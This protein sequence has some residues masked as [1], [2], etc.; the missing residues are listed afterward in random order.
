M[1]VLIAEDDMVSRR[2]LQSFLE[3]WGHEVVAAADGAEAWDLFQNGEFPVVITDWMMPKMD[4]VQL[5]R[6][7][8]SS[9]P[10][11]YV[12]IVLLTAKSEKE[13]IVE[14]MEAGADDFLAKPFDRNELRARLRAG[15]RYLRQEQELRRARD[16]LELRVRER[17][18]ELANAYDSLKNEMTH[19]QR[20]AQERDAAQQQLLQMERDKKRFYK[21]VILAVTQ[22]RFCLVDAEEIPVEGSL[23]LSIPFEDA[24]GYRSLRMR[25]REVIEGLLHSPEAVGDLVL[26]VGEAVTNAIKHAVGGQFDLYLTADR[27]LARISDRGS[28]IETEHLP[29]SILTAGFSTK[30]SMGMG[31]TLMLQ[32][33]DKVWLATGQEG[34]VIQMEK[35]LRPKTPE[36]DPLYEVLERFKVTD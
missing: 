32:L 13:D 28:G 36:E 5:I 9:S 33:T 6:S 12:F 24:Q 10:A 14:G 22:G 20:A 2:L 19:R 18:A 8:R 26:A 31:Y 17:T 23:I 25:L 7:I 4:G 15:E 21:E 1:R 16:E 27:L 30:V 3:K 34:T 35:S 11:G 29:A